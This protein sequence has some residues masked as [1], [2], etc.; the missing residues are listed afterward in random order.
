MPVLV[1]NAAEDP[2]NPPA[3]VAGIS[4]LYPNSFVRIEPRG[5]HSTNW[6]CAGKLMTVLIEQGRVNGL[7]PGCL[8]STEFIPFKVE[9]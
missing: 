7:Q 1:L 6:A 3:N 4:D 9:P 2:Q 5:G 8:K